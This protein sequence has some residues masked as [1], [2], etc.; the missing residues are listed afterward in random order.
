MTDSRKGRAELLEEL[1]QLRRS[2]E[3]LETMVRCRESER[4]QALADRRRLLD[5]IQVFLAWSRCT[6]RDASK[7]A[8]AMKRALFRL[9][10]AV[11]EIDPPE[12]SDA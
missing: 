7:Q 11:D 3:H 12:K 6:Y 2:R 5:E 10:D 9:S 1:A 4:D 8:R